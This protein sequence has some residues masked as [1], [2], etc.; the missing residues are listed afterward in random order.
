MFDAFLNLLFPPVCPVCGKRIGQAGAL[1]P[2]CYAKLTFYAGSTA[3][4]AS[5][6]VYGEVG[7]QLLLAL[8]Y[9][10]AAHLAPMMGKMAA[11]A[12]KSV[13]NGADVLVSVPLHR[14]RLFTRKYNQAALL[15][16]AVAKESG[17]RHDPFVLKRVKM[18]AKQSSRSKRFENVKNAFE[19]NK[20]DVK[21]K[22]VVV[23]DD[24]TTTGATFNA[25]AAVL[26]VAGAKE[27][28]LLTFA[29]A[30]RG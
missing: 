22:I 19:F 16:N 2:D 14:R 21:G 7:K 13:L 25:C 17:V 18:T 15:A 10:D 23:V 8:K 29:K 27:V 5:A 26:R 24:V 28:R 1:C 30:V 3:S 20:G 4:S 12:G 6:V 9:G 11:Q